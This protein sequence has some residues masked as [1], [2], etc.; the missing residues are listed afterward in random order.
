MGRVPS[1]NPCGRDPRARCDRRR[2]VGHDQSWIAKSSAKRCVYFAYPEQ[3]LSP[4]PCYENL[5]QCPVLV[6]LNKEDI[7][8]E[9]P[10]DPQLTVERVQTDLDLVALRRRAG[11]RS[12]IVSCK[13][14]GSIEIV[15][16]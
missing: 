10:N 11:V 2:D 1:Q 16:R 8:D 4:D 14:D 7:A 5:R 6:L 15:S 9:N 12:A 13:V 3:M